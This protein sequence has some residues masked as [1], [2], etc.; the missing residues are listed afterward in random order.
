MCI[1]SHIFVLNNLCPKAE[2]LLLLRR[3]CGCWCG[4]G[5]TAAQEVATLARSGL[6]QLLPAMYII[7]IYN[8][9]ASLVLVGSSH[10][11]QNAGRFLLLMRIFHFLFFLGYWLV[12]IYYR[13]IYIYV[14]H[15]VNNMQRV[16]MKREF[17]LSGF[18]YLVEFFLF[19][20][21]C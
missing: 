3:C 4:A 5:L 2:L 1:A 13:Y 21:L 18:L 14:E 7:C 11:R 10:K 9:S 15:R 6:L 17:F 20:F 12:F 19:Y 16:K 8:K